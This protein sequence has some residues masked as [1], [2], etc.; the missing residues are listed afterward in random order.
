[1]SAVRSGH[2][3]LR[4]EVAPDYLERRG[5]FRAEH[6]ALAWEAAGRGELLLGGVVGDPPEGAL[7]L[8]TGDGPEVAEQF[9][10]VD[11]YVNAGL[12]RRWTVRAWATVVGDSAAVPMRPR[13]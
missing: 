6:L 13:A 1:M 3:L 11:P 9:A 12:V 2:W 8:F 4:Y 10:A 5:Q 7:L